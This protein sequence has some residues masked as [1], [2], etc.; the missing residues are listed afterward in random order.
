MLNVGPSTGGCL[1]PSSF[2]LSS[3]LEGEE[4]WNTAGGFPPLLPLSPKESFNFPKDNCGADGGG[5]T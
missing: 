2:S 5:G 3:G 4:N 1:S